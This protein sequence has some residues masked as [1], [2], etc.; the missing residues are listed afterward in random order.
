MT[1]THSTATR[2]VM[3]DAIVDLLDVGGGGKIVF[4]DA[5]QNVVATCL[6]STPA[7]GDAVDAIATANTI[8]PDPAAIGGTIALANFTDALDAVVFQCT[9]TGVGGGG[10]IELSSVIVTEGQTISIN[11]G[12]TY[13]APD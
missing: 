12:L 9:V 3:A 7:F 2:T 10:D 8:F 4:L 11:S 13:E 5:V 1:V 6:L